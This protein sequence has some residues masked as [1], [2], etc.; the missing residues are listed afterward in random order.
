MDTE[1]TDLESLENSTKALDESKSMKRLSDDFGGK[2]T[3]N[4][5]IFYDKYIQLRSDSKA[6]LKLGSV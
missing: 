2:T 4:G 5:K 6:W 1:I 3:K